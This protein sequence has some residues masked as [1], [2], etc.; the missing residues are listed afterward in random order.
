MTNKEIFSKYFK[1]KAFAFCGF[2]VVAT[3]I[4]YFT[5]S[6]TSFFLFLIYLLIAGVI[7]FLLCMLDYNF[8]EKQYP[9][10]ILQLL[11]NSPLKEF[12]KINFVQEEN[13]KLVGEINGFQTSLVPHTTFT[14]KNVLIILIPVQIKE[15]GETQLNKLNK[16]FKFSFNGNILFVEAMLENYQIN[17]DFDKL[18]QLIINTTQKLRE[19]NIVPFEALTDE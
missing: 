3:L 7:L 12:S 14:R 18:N 1:A 5:K 10:V 13:D 11:S 9:K 16:Y 2:C 4:N 8:H 17:F 19:R 15:S 6:D